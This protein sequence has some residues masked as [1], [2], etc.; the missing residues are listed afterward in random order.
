[1]TTTALVGFTL[2]AL[3]TVVT[4]GLDSMLV[5]RYA[6]VGGRRAG[7]AVVAGINIGCLAWATA[8][9]AGLTALLTASRLAYDIVR[10][11]G[12]IYLIWFGARM[13]W[14]TFTRRRSDQ[15]ALA[16][17]EPG[18]WAA[19]RAGLVTN[20]LNPKPGVFYMSLLPQFLPAGPAN[21]TWGVLLVAIHL[22]IGLIWLPVLVWTAVRARRLFLRDR[23]R[24]WLDRITA[25]VLIGLGGKLAADVR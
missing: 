5:L 1:M 25:T 9:L 20:L 8:T 4:P 11:L 17:A 19:A 7:L 16:P 22:A 3:L 13:L 12:A 23:V 24:R 10:V 2:I 15:P 14:Q 18:R 6:L 21:L